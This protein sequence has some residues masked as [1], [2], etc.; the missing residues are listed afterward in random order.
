ML[1]QGGEQVRV[2]T[3][4]PAPVSSLLNYA[5]KVLYG[6]GEG[7][8]GLVGVALFYAFPDAVVQVAF[9]NDLPHLMQGLVHGV[10]LDEYILTG[11][12]FIYHLVDCPYLPGDSIEPLMQV[13]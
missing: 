12:V 11:D 8:Y 1:S 3:G 13:P 2:G 9:Q 7:G 10:Y 4:R 5:G 6:F